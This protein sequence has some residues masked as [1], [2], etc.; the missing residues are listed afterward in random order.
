MNSIQQAQEIYQSFPGRFQ[1][2]MLSTVSTEGVPDASYA[3]FIMNAQ[4]QIYLFVSGLST[5]TQN[6]LVRPQASVLIIEDEGGAQQIFARCRL[7][8]LCQA[9]F[10]ERNT[11]EWQYIADQFQD[12]F[13]DIVTVFRR[14]PDFR[15][16]ELTPTQ[17]RF[18]LGFGGA[19]HIRGNDLNR[20]VLEERGNP[21]SSSN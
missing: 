7:S 18:I 3:P 11:G 21:N 12:K 1:S 14:L 10:I 5:H 8:Y 9:K 16:V 15:V 6:L 4:K 13:G 17:G 19:Y 2:L 20:L